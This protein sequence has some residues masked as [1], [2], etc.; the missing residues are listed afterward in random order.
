MDINKEK[1][2]AS[3][4]G[5]TIGDAL[6]V[7]YEFKPRDSF[8]ATTLIGG[9]TWSQPVGT[10]SDDTSMTFASYHALK[11]NNWKVNPTL[12]KKHFLLWYYTECYSYHKLRKN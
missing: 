11:E 4:Y 8:K 5:L 3:L 7:P 2:K 10:W 9:G 6:G 12:F 1:L